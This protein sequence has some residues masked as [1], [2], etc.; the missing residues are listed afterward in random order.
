[1]YICSF[2]MKREEFLHL[3]NQVCLLKNAFVA[4]IKITAYIVLTI[5][6]INDE[7]F[8]KFLSNSL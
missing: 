2:Y 4:L 3:E 5:I 7:N 8:R 6:Q 1:M